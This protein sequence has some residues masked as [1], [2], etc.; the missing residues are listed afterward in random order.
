M[1]GE[2]PNLSVPE[3]L[4]ERLAR[5][6][7]SFM[8]AKIVLAAVEL[9]FF[10][11]LARSP[12]TAAALAEEQGCQLRGTEILL[13]A[14]VALGY[15]SKHEG[16]YAT[17]PEVERFLVRGRPDSL[18]HSM[19]HRNGLFR[20]WAVLEDTIRHGRTQREA[21]KPTLADPEANR[22]FIL[23][24]AE[25]SR[26]RVAPVIERLPLAGARRMVDLGGGPGHYACEA[27][28]RWPELQAVVVDLPLTV[29]VAQEYIAGQG[30]SDRVSTKVC[31]FFRE[32]PLDLGGP[33]DL[34]LISQV[35]HAEGPDENQALLQKV[36][37]HVRPGGWVVVS[38]NLVDA[39]RTS[40]KPGAV[41]AVNM[42]A[43]TERGRTY[44]AGEIA[45]WLTRAG[46]APQPV[47]HVAPRTALIAAR[48]AGG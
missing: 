27:V 2:R 6:S 33:A 39:D 28:R 44:T 26:G 31:D 14:L 13:D 32:D 43:G 11:L 17:T 38:E 29:Q 24:M 37:P 22:N 16:R 35:L 34:V 12:A 8:E 18:A 15:L 9:R 7:E 1:N 47:A 42:L 41:F 5:L 25:A 10:D 3:S 23:A 45:G 36:Q 20:S 46:F 48:K 40:P 30:L 4:P 21:E 19:A